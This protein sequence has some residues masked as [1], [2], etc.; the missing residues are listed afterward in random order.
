LEKRKAFENTGIY[1]QKS[2]LLSGVPRSVSLP[3]LGRAAEVFCKTHVFLW[4]L[5]ARTSHRKQQEV[6]MGLLPLTEHE[7]S[8]PKFGA[9]PCILQPLGMVRTF[10]QS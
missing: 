2:E 6:T 1:F 7:C 4:H 9:A 10:Q 5:E 8:A 3:L